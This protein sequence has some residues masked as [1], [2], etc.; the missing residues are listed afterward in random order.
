MLSV[1]NDSFDVI[2]ALDRTDF[3]ANIDKVDAVVSDYHMKDV[4][5][6]D[7]NQ[8][9]NLCNLHKKPLLL[10][11]GDIYPYHEC[12]LSKPFTGK[13]LRANIEKMLEK[14]YEIP[15]KKQ[16]RSTAA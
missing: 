13:S 12:Q 1:N 7:F 14:G 8:I 10:L 5:K 11:T 4:T 3:L 16:S 6:I 2:L 9:L 15:K